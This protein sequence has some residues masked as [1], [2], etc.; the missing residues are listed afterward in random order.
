MAIAFT[1]PTAT[2]RAAQHAAN[3]PILRRNGFELAAFDALLA[4][5]VARWTRDDR[6]LFWLA[7]KT[8]PPLTAPKVA[9]W[10]G[11][12]G[13]PI[14]FYHDT[15]PEP[16]GYF[17]LNPMVADFGHFWLGH[18]IVRPDLRNAGFGQV[19][20]SLGLELAFREQRAYRVSL[21]V[22]PEN[23]SAIRCYDRV[24]FVHVGD[25]HRFFPTTGRQ[26]RMLQMS[27]NRGQYL[28]MPTLPSLRERRPITSRQ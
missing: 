28:A 22:F 13:R 24:G 14:F 25:Q 4:P 9:A 3:R 20:I 6:E 27:I 26:H 7:P 2:Q 10:A 15:Q 21:V 17:E 11:T 5:L 12:D 8:P 19:M 23:T 1:Q 16:I 18:C